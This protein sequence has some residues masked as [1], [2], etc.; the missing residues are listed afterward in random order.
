PDMIQ[1]SAAETGARRLAGMIDLLRDECDADRPGRD[2]IVERLLEIM[3]VECL[4]WQGQETGG[5]VAS[6]GLLAGMRDPGVARALRAIHADI[7]F[8]W[9]VG[10]LARHAGMSRSVFAARFQKI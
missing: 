6:S 5:T 3:L 9:T 7:R 2:M 8:G 10:G 1:V 4:R